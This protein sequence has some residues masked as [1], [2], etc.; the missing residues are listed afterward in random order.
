MSQV[1]AETPE[2][3]PP[4]GGGGDGLLRGAQ[5]CGGGVLPE[6]F[7]AL[8]FGD[9][10]LREAQFVDRLALGGEVQD[11][12]YLALGEFADDQ[13]G[14]EQGVLAGEQF[15]CA[16]GVDECAV[17][18][19]HLGDVDDVE[20][21]QQGVAGVDEPVVQVECLGAGEGAVR[22]AAAQG[23]DAVEG[24]EKGG[25]ALGVVVVEG[26]AHIRVGG[27]AADGGD[28]LVGGGAIAA[29]RGQRVGGSGVG[30]VDEGLAA[31]LLDD[32]RGVLQGVAEVLHEGGHLE[33]P[34]RLAS[35]EDGGE[36]PDDGQG[37]QRHEKQRHD[38]PADRLPAKAHGLPQLDPPTGRGYTCASTNGASLL[39]THSYL[40]GP[41]GRRTSVPAARDGQLSGH[42]GRLPPG[43]HPRTDGRIQTLSR[44]EWPELFVR[45]ESSC[46]AVRPS[47]QEMEAEGTTGAAFRL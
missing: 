37:H 6:A 4:G 3:M 34:A 11:G 29:Q 43:V 35:G 14:A 25:E 13:G 5:G 8:A 27:V 33:Q 30:Q 10:Q 23:V 32:A 9:G 28:G 44:W 41:S 26:V 22:D 24:V 42:C 12:A 31:F 39:P 36:S 19:V 1:L 15:A 20:G 40:E 47:L 16:G 18:L 38:L 45:R 46:G 7:V 2:G 17:L 21:G